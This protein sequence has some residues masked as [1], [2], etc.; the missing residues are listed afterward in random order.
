[1]DCATISDLKIREIYL[2]AYVSYADAEN[3]R[4]IIID[5]AKV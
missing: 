3:S 4:H 5:N 1:M 2:L